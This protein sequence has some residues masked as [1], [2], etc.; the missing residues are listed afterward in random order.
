MKTKKV[1]LM[2]AIAILPTVLFANDLFKLNDV[3]ECK[4]KGE[5]RGNFDKAS[6]FKAAKQWFNGADMNTN[7]ASQETYSEVNGESIR[8][9]AAFNT[10]V[11][12]N[13][14]AGTFSE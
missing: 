5:V 10:Y 11:R 7:T 2:L 14:F 6:A 13:P 9:V 1:F 3:G 8:F 4:I 12:Y